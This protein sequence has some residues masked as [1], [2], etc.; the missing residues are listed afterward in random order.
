[1]NQQ[2][3]IEEI[4]KA[5]GVL[6]YQVEQE[7]LSGMFSKNSLVE[8]LF[9][10]VFAILYSAPDLRNL[11]AAGRN[12]AHLDLAD[13]T[14][15]FS[16]Q[17]TTDGSAAKVK[18]TLQGVIDDG[19]AKK[20]DRVVVFIL[21]TKRPSFTKA[22]ETKWKTICGKKLKFD[23]NEDVVA[24]P[25]LLSRIRNLPFQDILKVRKII[26]ESVIGE[27]YVD[28]L[29]L[30]RNVSDKHLAYEQKTTRYIPGVFIETRETKQ[31]CRSFCHPSLFLDRSIESADRIDL[32]SWNQFLDKSGVQTLDFPK[33]KPLAAGATLQEIEKHA[34]NLWLSYEPLLPLIKEYKHNGGRRSPLPNATPRQ[35]AFYEMNEH[36]LTNEFQY[37]KSSIDDIR[38]DF[39]SS[40]KRVLLITGAAGQGKTNLLCDLYENFIQK[41]EIPCAF[42]SGRE[43]GLKGTDSLAEV[44][45]TH[46]FGEKFPTL[47]DGF[48]R[49]SSEALKS[50]KPFVL[51]IDGLN[52]H[53][54]IGKFSQQLEMVVDGLF[55]YPGIRFLF[56]CR[57]EFFEDRFSN[58]VQGVLKPQIMLCRSTESRLSDEAREELLSVYFEYF[59]VDIRRVAE[60]VTKQLTKDLLLLR[61]F[62]E[63]YGKRGKEQ[64]YV[65]PDIRHFYR[66]ELFA[67][68]LEQK[69]RKAANFLQTLTT[70]ASPV[71]PLGELQRVLRLCLA[72]MLKRGQFVAVPFS[73]IPNE[74]RQALYALLDEELII[75]KDRSTDTSD[76]TSESVNFTFDELRDFLISKHLIEDVFSSGLSKFNTALK[77]F[78]P[79]SSPIEG[80]QR[81]LFYASRKPNHANFLTKYQQHDWYGKVYFRE[82]FNIDQQYLSTADVAAIRALLAKTD[83][84][85]REVARALAV[86]WNPLYWPTLNLG[87]LIDFVLQ[88]GSSAYESLIANDFRH[89][90]YNETPLAD[91]FC[92]FAE[93]CAEAEDF[94]QRISE[95][96]EF[97]RLLILILPFHA[98][99]WWRSPALVALQSLLS[100][101]PE[102]ITE[103]LLQFPIEKFPAHERILWRLLY[104]AMDLKADERIR[105]KAV[106]SMASLGTDDVGLRD[107]LERF[108]S[109]FE[110]ET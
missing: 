84:Q 75:R 79:Q 22:S 24:L 37:I 28:V 23:P 85:S 78:S 15:R 109:R 14:A 76:P 38:E 102:E 17:I 103:E 101:A 13:D 2:Q 98:D 47:E 58:L 96:R 3:A 69:L 41:H 45:R 36:V 97:V 18:K 10:P 20:Y 66:D 5:L 8:D 31:L 52:E 90:Y 4:G 34:Q 77:R 73:E 54:D 65:Q 50:N 82:V 53:R 33:L 59:E 80:I 9:L 56:S 106:S 55:A 93:V 91:K 30:V 16:M 81:F 94:R 72:Y 71:S 105:Q 108:M 67:L 40:Y 61:F 46:L 7:N 86:R 88:G 89:S 29:S 6:A 51:I 49:L 1:M 64:G 12:Y 62:C 44:L 42:V 60:H 39:E 57:T 99:S 26:A 21:Q 95:F 100:V 74:L 11:N 68:Y 35:L 63:G 32:P 92:D 43:L 104:D 110:D 87:I 25:S 83:W 27:E 107:E 48:A 70:V 19:L